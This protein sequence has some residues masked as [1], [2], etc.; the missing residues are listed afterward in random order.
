MMRRLLSRLVI[1]CALIATTGVAAPAA[2]N[3]AASGA[4]NLLLFELRLDHSTLSDS[5]VLYEVGSDLLLPLGELTRL[6]TLGITVDPEAQRASGFILSEERVFRLDLATETVTLSS[7]RE[8]FDSDGVRWLD[9]D[10]YVASRLLQRW[11]P[12]D[13]QADHATLI[14]TVVPREKLP[15]QYRLERERAGERLGRRN[16]PYLD[17]GYP[18]MP[19]DYRFLSV[20]FLD[21][22][23]GLEHSDGDTRRSTWG[24]SA[25]LTGDLLWMEGSLHLSAAKGEEK[26]ERRLTLARNDP[27]GGLLGPLRARSLTIGHLGLPALNNVLRGS[28]SGEGL[29]VTNR[30]LTQSTGYDLHTLRGELPPGWDVTL[31]YNDALTGFQSS[32]PDGLYEFAD[33]PLMYGTNEFRLLFNGPLGQSRVERHLFILDQTLTKPGELVYS[34]SGQRTDDERLRRSAQFDLGL[35]KSLSLTGGI[36]TTPL[37]VDGEEEEFYNVGLR[38]ALFGLLINGDYV[39]VREGGFLSEIDLKTRIWRYALSLTHTGLSEDYASDFFPASSDQVRFRDRARLS[40]A[41]RLGAKLSLP[42]TLDYT[43]EEA[44]S[45]VIRHDL[46][47]RLSLN[48]F[49]TNLTNATTWSQ[50]GDDSSSSGTLQLS[51]RVAGVGLSS[52]VAYQ[53]EPESE[54]TSLALSSDVNFGKA[55]RFNL[56]LLHQIDPNQTTYSTGVTHNF[57]SFNIGLNG[58]YIDTGDYTVG[59]QIFMALGRDP[60]AGRWISSWQP[61]AGAGAIS[62]H[63]FLD[64]NQNG[65]FDPGEE[66]I[67]GAGFKINEG[68]RLPG[69]SDAEGRVCLT[70][71]SPKQY[72]D[73]SLDLSTLED[74]QWMPTFQGVRVLPRP[75]KVQSIDF[76]VV[77]TGEVDGTVYLERDGKPRGIGNALVELVDAQGQVAASATSSSDGYYVIQG[78]RPGDYKARVSPEQ[79]EKLGLLKTKPV[80]ITMRGDGEFIYGL[81]FTLQSRMAATKKSAPLPPVAPAQGAPVPQLFTL[82]TTTCQLSS[83]CMTIMD[84]IHKI[85]YTPELIPVESTLKMVRLK[86]GPFTSKTVKKALALARTITPGA[87]SLQ[88]GESSVIYAGAYRAQENLDKQVRLFTKKGFK[89]Y[90][91]PV[92]IEKSLH[93]LRFGRFATQS[94]AEAVARTAASNGLQTTVIPSR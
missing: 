94:A 12:I 77:M 91:E 55:S 38:T 54:V 5:L 46:Q 65:R 17:P 20:P 28:G 57:G 16:A 92:K 72:A 84:K 69:S 56:G 31:Y 49:G 67:E 24:Y 80:A 81:D 32:R 33:Q 88:D 59:V 37:T 76:P 43:R 21:Q 50:I 93:L 9:D 13:L 48:L 39:R 78:V 60:R 86:L 25:N 30:P 27:E 45:G 3:P 62:A 70:R 6:L 73:I 34:V 47:G 58:R 29:L 61:L 35:A 89:V 87:Y 44:R 71:L 64:A 40:G 53:I 7:G 2:S 26:I 1:L 74:P 18:R 41:L 10:L 85:G 63:T 66:P 68:G 19:S 75:G 82:E 79:L 8:S 36:V 11:L 4:P 23:L 15:L 52:Q 14:M 83:D 90:L 22:T 42:L 51:R